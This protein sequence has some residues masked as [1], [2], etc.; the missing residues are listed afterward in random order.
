MTE[1]ARPMRKRLSGVLQTA[2]EF[3]VDATGE[4]TM[5]YRIWPLGEDGNELPQLYDRLE[6]LLTQANLTQLTTIMTAL[7]TR[8]KNALI[9]P[10]P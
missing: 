5:T 6:P 7:N 4:V 8:A 3:R 1:F 9:E 2:F 10:P